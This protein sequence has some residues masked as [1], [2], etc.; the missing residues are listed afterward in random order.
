MSLES[1]VAALVSAASNLTSQVAGKMAGIDQKVDEV[2]TSVQRTINEKAYSRFYLDPMAGNDSNDGR[3]TS[4]AKKTLLAIEREMVAGSVV[5]IELMNDLIVEADHTF[6]Y[7]QNIWIMGYGDRVPKIV[8]T[9]Y[10]DEEGYHRFGSLHRWKNVS[11]SFQDIQFDIDTSAASD[12]FNFRTS[13]NSAIQ[14]NASSALAPNMY[15]RF[16][17]CD[18][19]LFIEKSY[20]E[21]GAAANGMKLLEITNNF[22]VFIA[23]NTTFSSDEVKNKAV[24][25]RDASALIATDKRLIVSDMNLVS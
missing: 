22:A 18:L 9:L 8:F 16:R 25:F 14:T 13:R 23:S 2:T 5:V 11:L 24:V 6:N 10:T 17:A 19:S 7:N 21:T 3:T 4:T 1:Q 20:A 12:G 15:V